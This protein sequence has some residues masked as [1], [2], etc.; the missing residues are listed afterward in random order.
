MP[1]YL[2]DTDLPENSEWDRHI[3]DQLYGG[4]EWYR[5]SHYI[6]GVAKKHTEI[7]QRIFAGYKIHDITNGVHA[8]T[9]ASPPI[10]RLFDRCI[11]GW[12]EDNFN[13]RHALSLP[14]ADLWDAHAQA[15]SSLLDRVNFETNSGMEANVLTFGFAPSNP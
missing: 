5:L 13:L 4:N 8:D 12:R 9:W 11:P 6:N 7:S 3:T 10:Q 2:L 14:A 1:V 15:K